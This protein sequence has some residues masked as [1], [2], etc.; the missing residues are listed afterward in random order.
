MATEV[1]PF[2]LKYGW[3]ATE[4]AES[5]EK[6]AY[7]AVILCVH[8]HALARNTKAKHLVHRVDRVN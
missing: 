2:R 7:S 8:Q 3:L 1:Y 5:I 4:D 6:Y